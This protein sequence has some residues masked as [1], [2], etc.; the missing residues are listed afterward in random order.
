MADIF[1]VSNNE[2]GKIQVMLEHTADMLSDRRAYKDDC[3]FEDIHKSFVDNLVGNQTYFDN[4]THQIDVYITLDKLKK[5]DKTDELANF[6][7]TNTDH[8]KVIIFKKA[9]PKLVSYF[10]NRVRS[11]LVLNSEVMSSRSKFILNPK[12]RL[13]SQEEQDQIKDEYKLGYKSDNK[14]LCVIKKDDPMSR[15]YRLQPEEIIEIDRSSI[16]SGHSIMYRVRD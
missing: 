12:Y 9:T 15:Y 5:I 2:S 4:G 1:Q 8:Y 16:T 6:L 14:N 3:T 10:N 11:E 7:T 13:L